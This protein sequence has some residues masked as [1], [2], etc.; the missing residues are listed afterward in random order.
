MKKRI[1][2]LLL[3][4]VMV[5]G[6]VPM[7]VLAEEACTH[8]NTTETVADNGNSTHTTTVTCDDCG[9][10]VT[11]D[12]INI[13]FFEFAQ[14]ASEQ[15]FWAGLK[16]VQ[17]AREQN[18][19]VVNWTYKGE[20][21]DAEKEA[22]LAMIDWM[23]TR[24]W[25][26]DLSETDN[27][28]Y[29]ADPS[30]EEAL[31]WAVGHNA[32]FYNMDTRSDLKIIFDAESAGMYDI[33]VDV[34]KH[35]TSVGTSPID[36]GVDAGGGYGNI[37]VNGELVVEHYRFAADTNEDGSWASHEQMATI[38]L[39]EV[40]LNEGENTIAIRTTAHVSDGTGNGG[41]C[42]QFVNAINMVQQSQTFSCED[43]YGDGK[44]DTCGAVIGDCRHP[45][46]EQVYAST[47]GD[48]THNVTF[49]CALCGEE[50]LTLTETVDFK[51]DLKKAAE[52]DFWAALT[53]A[54]PT[55]TGYT[56][57]RIGG[58]YYGI[59]M[60]AE[61]KAAYAELTAWL[62]ENANWT[63]NDANGTFLGSG[64][65]RLWLSTDDNMPWALLLN[66]YYYN[67]TPADSDLGLTIDAPVAGTYDVSIDVT[68]QGS[69]A[70]DW[71]ADRGLDAGGA[72]FHVYVNGTVI[73]D[74][75]GEPV[76]YTT[77]AA[78]TENGKTTVLDLGELELLAG[79]NEF[80]IHQYGAYH[81]NGA[82]GYA[83]R[84]NITLKAIDMTYSEGTVACVDETGDGKCDICGVTF[85]DCQHKETEDSVIT[86]GDG[87]HKVISVCANCGEEVDRSETVIDFRAAFAEASAQDFWAGLSDAT[88]KNGGAIK[89]AGT[90]YNSKQDET[91]MASYAA[92]NAWLAENEGWS[93]DNTRMDVAQSGTGSGQKLY[94]NTTDS[95]LWGLSHGSYFIGFEDGRSSLALN[96]NAPEDGV[97]DLDI[98]AVLAATNATDFDGGTI[99]S[100]VIDPNTGEEQGDIQAADAGGVVVDIYV[101]DVLA[102]SAV[103]LR[104]TPAVS[105]IVL[106]DLALT[107]GDNAIELRIMG[108]CWNNTTNTYRSNLNLQSITL[109][110][111]YGVVNC[112]DTAEQT[113]VS[114]GD[115]THTVTAA[116]S[117]CGAEFAPTEAEL[118]VIDIDFVEFAQEAAKQDFW[119]QLPDV[120]TQS[121]KAVKR[122][123][124]SYVSGNFTTVMTEE[125]DAAYDAMRKWQEE[126][127]HWSFNED[128]MNI[129]HEQGNMIFL[130]NSE[131]LKW[132]VLHHSYYFNF[133]NDNRSKMALTVLADEA[134]YYQL[135]MSYVPQGSSATDWPQFAS[136]DAGGGFVD[137]YVN[138]ELVVSNFSFKCDNAQNNKLHETNLATVYLQNGANDIVI[139]KIANYHG[140]GS[141]G[142]TGRSNAA[143]TDLTFTEVQTT[144]AQTEAV[145]IAA[146]DVVGDS[147][148]VSADTNTV[149]SSVESVATAALD[150]EGNIVV[151][152]VAEG[153]TVITV[154]GVG[155]DGETAMASGKVLV[156]VGLAVTD[157]CSDADGDK[158]CDVCGGEIS[159]KHPY[160]HRMIVSNG[161]GTH[162]V[163]YAC[164]LCDEP[165]TT[166]EALPCEDKD[167]TPDGVC[168]WCGG[169][170]TCQHTLTTVSYAGNSN[171]TH[172]K[173]VTCKLCNTVLEEAVVEDCVDEDGDNFCDSCDDELAAEPECDHTNTTTETVSNGDKTHTTTVTCECGHEVSSETVDCTDEDKDTKCDV[174][175]AVIKNITKAAFAGSNMTLGNELE[176]NF[177]MTKSKLPAGDYTAY[178]TQKLADGTERVTELAMADWKTMGSYHKISARI[179][180]KE[181]SDEL[182]IEIRDAEGYVYNEAYF[183]S[184]RGYADRAM[185]LESTTEYVR[186]MMVDMLNYGASAQNHFKYNTSDLANSELTEEERALATGEVTCTN[187]QV[188]D[189]TIYGANLSLEDSILLNVFFMGLKGKDISAMYAMVTFTGY[190]DV[191]HEIRVEGSEFEKYGTSGDIYKVVVDDIVLADAK[192]LVTVTVYNA[193]GTTYGAASDSVESYVARV[194]NTGDPNGLYANIMKFA[195]S[196]YNYIMNK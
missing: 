153:Q 81:N 63:I 89:R 29:I 112:V 160:T 187:N 141:A 60:T 14:A 184:V 40:A 79:A 3:A 62:D 26:I 86:N 84:N 25:R 172:E 151:T 149:S 193:D 156:N 124:T 164:D 170:F 38:D 12:T 123:G 18:V 31:K 85:T 150:A 91:Q 67:S 127:M 94:F 128:G 155:I 57:K 70:T 68:T 76:L 176:V 99:Y 48:G 88:M 36:T 173:T 119:A 189:D 51:A 190:D 58:E 144:L 154:N 74:E 110:E 138:G 100:T 135:D 83:G 39:G 42:W 143:I 47:N 34:V 180:A 163:F 111:K 105:N 30:N 191:S 95:A 87:T 22:R 166:P 33:S 8:A 78:N 54:N 179:A 171:G 177:L 37:Y 23:A 130:S 158:V 92:L 114:N 118:N 15:D 168:D 157:A 24:D 132:G 174:C 186:I 2:S 35:S 126:T 175:G 108:N 167:E 96:L 82:T 61:E 139:K 20:K 50:G 102:V 140:Y 65:K 75:A 129:K 17:T 73:A 183:T 137:I 161:D 52:Q 71:P 66:A 72:F 93:F 4:V 194:A 59:G 125:E 19:K 121:G 5:L 27:R 53:D 21:T 159:C 64:G 147:V 181:M 77:K 113:A 55:S 178:I 136:T 188:K 97:Y 80:V 116:C 1:L 46:V 104:G 49:K 169:E 9:E 106:E 41:R 6:L 196:A 103:D 45:E 182:H 32:Y 148:A 7:T 90:L 165:A 142:Y 109:T 195:T 43:T 146:A 13:D 107:A 56:S 101:N 10:T 134:G 122:I 131:E 120:T 28:I 115:E 145:T 11:Q 117:A 152:P 44:C 192:Q 133:S 162:N 69:T 98:A 185:N 16:T